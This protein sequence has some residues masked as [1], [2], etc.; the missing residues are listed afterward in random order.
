MFSDVQLPVYLDTLS[1][2]K[3]GETAT[4][5][6]SIYVPDRCRE[7]PCYLFLGEVGDL[8]RVYLDGKLIMSQGY[9]DGKKSLAKHYPVSIELAGKGTQRVR[10]TLEIESLYG[11]GFGL[12]RGPV[13][14]GDYAAVRSTERT[15]T[16][17]TVTFPLM[18]ALVLS[19]FGILAILL[20]SLMG[21]SRTVFSFGI[22][23][24][25]EAAFMLSF[26][27]L[28]REYLPVTTAS[29]LHFSLRLI[30][31][32]ALFELLNA[33]LLFN[34]RFVVL[35]R[36]LFAAFTASLG[37]LY[38]RGAGYPDFVF[39]TQL[40]AIIIVGT[41]VVGLIV[42]LQKITSNREFPIREGYSLKILAPTLL[43]LTVFQVWDT[44]V[45]WNAFH[46]PYLIKFYLAPLAMSFAIILVRRHMLAYEALKESKSEA[47]K[48]AALGRVAVELSHDLKSPLGALR[49]GAVIALEEENQPE[50]TKAVLKDVIRKSELVS[51]RIQELCN[52]AR[53][54]VQERSKTNLRQLVDEVR[55]ELS[56]QIDAKKISVN[57]KVPEEPVMVDGESFKRAVFN[58]LDNAIFASSS[59]GRIDIKAKVRE[60]RLVFSVQDHGKGIS[61]EHLPLIF[62]PYFTK[63]KPGG[64]G[65]GLAIVDRISRQHNGYVQVY[66]KEKLGSTFVMEIPL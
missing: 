63:N 26:S 18:Q 64:T 58:L 6:K 22:F 25:T 14:V 7:I 54:Q 11:V 50:Y 41:P 30:S 31:D 28:P 17:Q 52:F 49:D 13:F 42:A 47:E 20:W 48:D 16:L 34:H 60:G 40:A 9:A 62:E 23:A 8:V 15:M 53:A 3:A 35:V 37:Y 19:I 29:A 5:S 2:K 27:F 56:S 55:D 10:V 43:V 4:V 59:N 46:G 44:A 32:W 21:L 57:V 12:T 66:S 38:L 51:S 39:V 1:G 45:F 24:L 36:I 61:E 33:L 65:L